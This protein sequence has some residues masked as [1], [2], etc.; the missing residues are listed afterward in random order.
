[1]LVGIGSPV[2]EEHVIEVARGAFGD[3]SGCLGASVVDV[4]RRDRAQLAGLPLDGGDDGRVLVADI[5]VDQLR[6]QVEQLSALTVPDVGPGGIDD[7]HRLERPLC[8][9]GVEDVRT[10]EVVGTSPGLDEIGIDP[11]SAGAISVEV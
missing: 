9:P 4:L 3:E 7:R 1:M 5:R 8:L 2:R 6:R 10:V 11:V